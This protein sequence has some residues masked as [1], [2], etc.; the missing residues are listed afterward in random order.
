[1]ALPWSSFVQVPADV[2]LGRRRGAELA[3]GI[4]FQALWAVGLLLACRMV[5]HLADR[6]VV[7]QGG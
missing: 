7:V 1:M 6:K 3:E 5:L 2:W 4:A